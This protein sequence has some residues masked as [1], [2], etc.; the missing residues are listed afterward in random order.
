MKRFG[1]DAVRT[2]HYPNDP[3]FLDLTDELGLYVIDEADIESHAFWGSLSDDPRYLTQWVERVARMAQ[4]DSITRRSSHGRSATNRAMA[5]TTMPPPPGSARY[6]PLE[7]AALR[8]RDPVRLAGDQRRSPTSPARCTRRSARSSR[9]RQNGRSSTADHVRVLARHGQQNGTLGEYW[10]RSSR[11]PGSRVGS[12]GSGGTTGSCRRSRWHEPPRVRRRL[13]RRAQR[14]QLLPRRARSSPIAH[15][16]PRSGSTGR[17][18]RRS[19][20]GPPR[21]RRREPGVSRSRIASRSVTSP[22]CGPPGTSRSMATSSQAGSY[23][24]RGSPPQTSTAVDVPGL[25]VP[26]ADGGERWL[27]IRRDDRRERPIGRPPDLRSR[28]RSSRSTTSVCRPFG[29]PTRRQAWSS[30]MRVS[31]SR[32]SWPPRRASRSGAPRR[33]TT[34]SPASPTAGRPG[35]SIAGADARWRERLDGGVTIV[36]ARYRTAAGCEIPGRAA[37]RGARRRWRAHP[38]DGDASR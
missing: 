16:S 25:R 1:F 17:S 32:R 29:R 38:G 22:G 4:R 26:D 12:S 33:T 10:T 14:R 7:T 9:T 2:S 31:S 28:R 8:G 6:D 18:P 36:H 24:C 13:R 23:R 35:G 3:A 5:P 15:R 34:A 27:T 21:R 37:A 11:R 30:T 19:G 20:C